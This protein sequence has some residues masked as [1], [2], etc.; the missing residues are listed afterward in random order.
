MERH[1]RARSRAR[2][3]LESALLATGRSQAPSPTFV[4]H[5]AVG[6]GSLEANAMKQH[7][8][9]SSFPLAGCPCA[10]LC[11]LPSP[12]QRHRLISATLF[13]VG[14]SLELPLLLQPCSCSLLPD[15]QQGQGCSAQ[16]TIA[17]PPFLRR[18]PPPPCPEG[19][20]STCHLLPLPD[21][22]QVTHPRLS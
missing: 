18:G 9:R 19:P 16:I 3:P 7:S 2:Q 12:E 17:L 6:A 15:K 13:A 5:L 22:S 20:A 8:Q 1:Q 11:D 14:R 10:P 21:T 4:E